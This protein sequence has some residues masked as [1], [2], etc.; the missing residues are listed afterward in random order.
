MTPRF[1]NLD[2]YLRKYNLNGQYSILLISQRRN[3]KFCFTYTF[4]RR[5]GHLKMLVCFFFQWKKQTIK[6]PVIIFNLF[7]RN[8]SQEYCYT[9]VADRKKRVR[10]IIIEMVNFLYEKNILQA[11]LFYS[12]YLLIKQKIRRNDATTRSS[13]WINIQWEI[14]FSIFS[15]K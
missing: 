6:I 7:I 15:V 1:W 2:E 3:A 13:H 9:R 4:S 12:M 11:I 10:N 14:L 5:T 8:K